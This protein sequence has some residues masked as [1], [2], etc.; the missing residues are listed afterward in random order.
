MRRGR[1]LLDR[2][3]GKRVWAIEYEG[4]D[5]RIHRTH[6]PAPTKREARDILDRINREQEAMRRAG[7]P[8]K[9]ATFRSF[10]EDVYLDHFEK[11]DPP[12]TYA[13]RCSRANGLM[14]AL[15]DKP[16]RAI[17][18]A[19]ITRFLK[20]RAAAISPHTGRPY[21]P[22]SINR[23]IALL[24]S[25]FN[26]ADILE[27]IDAGKS[28]VRHVK[29]RREKNIR[30]RILQPNEEADLMANAAPHLRPIIQ[31]AIHTG[32][33]CGELLSLEWSDVD[34]DRG[35]VRVRASL[36]KSGR[37]RRVPMCRTVHAILR[38]MPGVPDRP[39]WGRGR[40]VFAHSDGTPRKEVDTAF[41]AACGR[42]NVVGLWFHDLRRTAGPRWYEG[43]VD[44][45][46]V[47]RWLGHGD[48]KT[49][50]RYL[51]VNL[52][53]RRDGGENGAAGRTIDGPAT[54][55]LKEVQ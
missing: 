21:K 13:T 7:G 37:E 9:I 15:G 54:G 41:R 39:E 19:D 28:P 10:V 47:S 23:D 2:R 25:V 55:R 44:I 12:R 4:W 35:T 17:T 48:L 3:R 52:D 50:L 45:L 42:A 11:L 22:A 38:A 53:E 5:G 30:S 20:E 16:L 18:R 32:L 43:G 14:A 26:L 49:T 46:R 1:V 36:A 51:H 24:S 31:T 6:T 33:R 27:Y 8:P 34:F 40:P 29:P